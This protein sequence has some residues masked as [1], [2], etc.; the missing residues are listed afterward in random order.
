MPVKF[1]P[2]ESL[3][4]STDAA[5]ISRMRDGEPSAVRE[6]FAQY[7][8]RMLRYVEAKIS[9]SSDAEDIVQEVFVNSLR[10]L[11]VFRGNSSLW[12]W[13][14]AIAR[15]EIADYFRKKYAK[16]AIRSLPWSQVFAEIQV[17]EK[18]KTFDQ[19]TENQALIH[20][21]LRTLT[22]MQQELLQLK[23]V[24]GKTVGEIAE[25]W[26]KTVKSIESEL[27]RARTAFKSQWAAVAL[28]E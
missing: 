28:E 9:N 8:D 13:M 16:S 24:D 7:H 1:L 25:M 22:K 26:G 11:N 12:T 14:V 3:L 10:Q 20:A 27:F 18:P 6:W 23:Y 4:T 21:V 15:H 2:E 5:L 17:G 19:Q